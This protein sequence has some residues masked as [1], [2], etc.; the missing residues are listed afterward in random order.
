MH[1]K[2]R[3]QKILGDKQIYDDIKQVKNLLAE[4]K[5]LIENT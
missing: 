5:S 1:N 3:K 4:A 2:K